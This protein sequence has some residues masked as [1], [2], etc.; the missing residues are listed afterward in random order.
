M[1]NSVH[2]PV[3]STLLTL[4]GFMAFLL[5]VFHTPFFATLGFAGAV[6]MLHR[7][8]RERGPVLAWSGFAF[9]ILGISANVI[10]MG[11]ENIRPG[12]ES[13]SAGL[14]TEGEQGSLGSLFLTGLLVRTRG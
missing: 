2:P 1:D 12:V 8:G 5:T 9:L 11:V 10:Y 7:W 4:C 14:R 3:E 13:L 6:N